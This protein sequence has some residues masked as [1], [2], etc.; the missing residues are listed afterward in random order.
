MITIGEVAGQ[1]LGLFEF[2]GQRFQDRCSAAGEN[3]AGTAIVQRA[4]NRTA[5]TTTG[6]REHNLRTSDRHG[7]ARHQPILPALRG[8]MR[9]DLATE[10]NDRRDSGS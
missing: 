8:S 3:Q 5:Q 10:A 2:R 7:R 1:H 9:V 4:S 6:T